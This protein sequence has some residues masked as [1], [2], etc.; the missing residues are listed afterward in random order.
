MLSFLKIENI[1]L[2]EKLEL[3]FPATLSVF[4]GETGA[5]KSVLLD[6]VSLVLGQRADIGLIRQGADF[7]RVTACFSIPKTAPVWQ[8]LSDI[9]IENEDEIII[10]RILQRD[11][12]SKAYI[13]DTPVTAGFLK[14]IGSFLVEI[15]GQY[16]AYKLLSPAN[17]LPALDAFAKVQLSLLK[18]AFYDWKQAEKNWQELQE[19]QK[20]ILTDQA[21][22]Q[23]TVTQLK[24]ANLQE[25][26]EERLVEQRTILNNQSKIIESLQEAHALMATENSG[27]ESLLYKVNRNLE[28][29]N[30]LSGNQFER[31]CSD[32]TGITE[33]FA[34]VLASLEGKMNFMAQPM[35]L[36]EI[37][38]RLYFLRGLARKYGVPVAELT[39]IRADFELK[40]TEIE[41]LDEYLQ[42]SAI[43][44]EKAKADYKALADSV[45]K[46]RQESAIRLDEQVNAELPDLKLA[47]ARFK[48]EVSTLPEQ[49]WNENGINQVL[50]TVSTNPGQP[51]SPIQKIA[52]GGELARFMLGLKVVLAGSEKTPVLI[53]DEV[54]T[55]VGGGVADAVGKRLK[56]LSVGHQVLVITHSPQVASYGDSHYIVQ[57]E[58][59]NDVMQTQVITAGQE[60]RMQE[61]A[62]M[63]SGATL[64]ETSLKMAKELVEESCQRFRN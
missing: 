22:Y 57:K 21:Y 58:L 24:A 28:R 53:F 5:G 8:L 16:A 29:A 11:G 14:E 15:Y 38:D 30:Q 47:K 51:F 25:N 44:K 12:K 52:S 19:K 4:T 43:L 37:E 17:H 48:T 42:K 7:A 1:V 50:F 13:N 23:E 36:E 27:I 49:D 33:S 9:G 6:A 32:L 20:N 18:K 46:T 10:R 56:M 31:L 39:K 41:N 35:E 62:R 59:K 26:E 3:S 60:I 45:S 63:L 54:D 2:I 40:L 64:T 61:I 34:D 55:G